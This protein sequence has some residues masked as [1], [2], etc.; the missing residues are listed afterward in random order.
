LFLLLLLLLLVI[1]RYLHST[2]WFEI[3]YHHIRQCSFEKLGVAIGIEPIVLRTH[4]SSCNNEAEVEGVLLIEGDG[5]RCTLGARPEGGACS[6][7]R[8]GRRGQEP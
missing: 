3:R 6:K 5:S 4:V 7:G 2:L 8:E 1:L